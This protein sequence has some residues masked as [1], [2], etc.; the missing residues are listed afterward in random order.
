[1]SEFSTASKSDLSE[2]ANWISSPKQTREWAGP[3]VSYPIDKGKLPQQ[4][5]WSH[6]WSFCLA[7]EEELVGFGQVVPKAEARLHLARL[8]VK[9]SFRGKGY[10]VELANS[11]LSYALDQNPKTISLNVFRENKPAIELYKRLGFIAAEREP[12][13][14]KSDAQYMVYKT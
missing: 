8:I 13:D 14:S 7:N 1:M 9:P 3:R 6:A 4:V 11:I 10:G 2:V 12:G 5:E